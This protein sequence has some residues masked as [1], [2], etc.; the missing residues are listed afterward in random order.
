MIKY[1]FTIFLIFECQPDVGENI[2]EQ[3]ETKKDGESESEVLPDISLPSSVV[4]FKLFCFIFVV[5]IYYYVILLLLYL[6]LQI[7]FE[8]IDCRY[9]HCTTERSTD[10]K[11]C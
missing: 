1:F 4:S 5:T 7:F 3:K 6:L 8:I 11:R 9:D 2:V 10:R